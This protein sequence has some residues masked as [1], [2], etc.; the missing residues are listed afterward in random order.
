MTSVTFA[1]L[2]DI[3]ISEQDHSWGT[4]G[5][6]AQRLLSEVILRLNTMDDLDFVLIT[7]DALDVATPFELERFTALI[8]DLHQPWHF[9]P[10]NH[11]GYIDPRHPEA[12]AP[13]E[14]VPQ[15]DPRMATPR[16]DV[17][18]A[19]W[20]RP[21]KNGVRL[22]GLDS[23]MADTWNGEISSEQLAWLRSELETHRDDL[24]I[25]AIHHPISNLIARNS[26][27]FWSNFICDN[28][29][30]V[31]ALLDA[32]PNVR[33]VAAGHHHANRII[34]RGGRLHVNTAS[35]TGY[36][37]SYRLI[38]LTQDGEGW[39]VSITTH[40]PA[41]EEVLKLAYDLALE[42]SIAGLYDPDD[43]AAW[44]RMTVGREADI[45][46]NCVLR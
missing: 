25:V 28:G 13:H 42:S 36:P 39:Q 8:K 15:I 37:C 3:H 12:F 33:M 45:S 32:Y 1:H 26:Q 16:P 38:R 18:R 35:L 41:S 46:C 9:I 29:P 2:T 17:Q 24:V 10:G 31:E 19:Y 20:S 21:I 14:A 44:V 30:E 11:D 22:I 40:S 27:L 5:T 4:L 7:G 6:Q 43:P 34:R 23:R